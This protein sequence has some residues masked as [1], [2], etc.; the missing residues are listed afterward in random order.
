MLLLLFTNNL[1][2]LFYFSYNFFNK[3]VSISDVILNFIY[4]SII[5]L[6]LT[7]ILFVLSLIC[8]ISFSILLLPSAFVS[9]MLILKNKIHFVSP[10]YFLLSS[11]KKYFNKKQSIIVS[12]SLLIISIVFTKRS[13]RWGD[14]DAW[15]IWN[16]HAEFL[17][18]QDHWTNLFSNHLAWSHPDYPLLLP[19]IVGMTWKVF[20]NITPVIPSIIAYFILICT[21]FSA[22]QTLKI[23]G[24]EIAGLIFFVLVAIDYRFVIRAASQ[25]S[26][27]LLA[28]FYLLTIILISLE[29]YNNKNIVIA[30][31]F[32]S[33]AS[34]WIK[35]EGLLF[36]VISTFFYFLKSRN[37]TMKF[38]MHYLLGA[39]IPLMM[40]I[41]FKMFYATSNDIV[42][43]QS[44][45]IT[46]KLLDMNRYLITFKFIVT[47][48][49]TKNYILLILIFSLLAVLINRKTLEMKNEFAI[50]AT[51]LI[52]YFMI[53]IVT[54]NDL[55]WHLTT[56]FDRLI[57]QIY[58]SLLFLILLTISKNY[59]LKDSNFFLLRHK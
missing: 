23:K 16:L 36:F 54:P 10:K 19:S 46:E 5:S 15:A 21:L 1:I 45:G 33:A 52:G 8:D 13:F 14:W 2:L 51:L 58:P 40:I 29:N 48:L 59:P 53:Y 12:V 50:I 47:T 18:D 28:L 49:F 20:E 56:S 35:N 22:Y 4:A 38:F 7:G 44:N 43:G 17:T 6:T 24:A 9:I 32:F 3:L 42:S 37:F 26:D 41:I 31:G 30:I 57:H 39:A 11:L 27:T 25:Y 34:G 55:V